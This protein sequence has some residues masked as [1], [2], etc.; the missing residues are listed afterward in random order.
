M[1]GKLQK[2][3]SNGGDYSA[4]LSLMP[5]LAAFMVYGIIRICSC[6]SES[7]AADT[8]AQNHYQQ[9]MSSISTSRMSVAGTWL[10]CMLTDYMLNTVT[11]GN[12][13]LPGPIQLQASLI[14]MAF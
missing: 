6:G 12:K 13:H 3:A 10:E 1:F 4:C 7:E 9:H 14:R 11:I 8:S 2:I 5:A